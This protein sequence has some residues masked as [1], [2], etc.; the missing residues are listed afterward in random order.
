VTAESS[1]GPA[2]R[3]VGAAWDWNGLDSAGYQGRLRDLASWVS[4]LVGTYED[5]VELPPCWPLHESLRAELAFFCYW[6]RR[7]ARIGRDPSEGIRWHLSM[8]LAA[9]RWRAVGACRHEE[10]SSHMAQLQAERT[11]ALRGFLARASNLDAS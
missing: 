1:I 11:T 10:P 8:R 7:I 3:G 5:W 2:S 4:W 9:T 6:H